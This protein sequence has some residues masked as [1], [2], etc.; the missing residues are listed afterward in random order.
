MPDAPPSVMRTRWYVPSQFRL[1]PPGGGVSVG[2]TVKVGVGG[3][4]VGVVGVDVEVGSS[5]GGVFVLDAGASVVSGIDAV[6][7]VDML[8][9]VAS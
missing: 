8:V 5:T 9:S 1:T 4:I 7:V 6:W 2:V 3:A